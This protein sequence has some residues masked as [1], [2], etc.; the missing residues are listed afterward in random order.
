MF[1]A[2]NTRDNRLLFKIQ[3]FITVNYN[4]TNEQCQEFST[5]SCSVT[6]NLTEI[7]LC[8]VRYLNVRIFFIQTDCLGTYAAE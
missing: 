2:T 5:Y 4:Y 7:A 8:F 6:R 1:R 3:Y